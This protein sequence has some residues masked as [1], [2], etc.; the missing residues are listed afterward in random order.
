MKQ[1][2]IMQIRD[3]LSNNQSSAN[4][5]QICCYPIYLIF[6]N[7]IKILRKSLTNTFSE[8]QWQNIVEQ[9]YK[10]VIN[11]VL[12]KTLAYEYRLAKE[13]GLIAHSENAKTYIESDGMLSLTNDIDWWSYI[14][15]KYSALNFILFN[16]VNNVSSYIKHVSNI[17]AN[18][19]QYL[20]KHSDDFRAL[21]SI[22]LFI[23]DMHHDRSVTAFNFHN[24]TRWYLKDR[25]TSNECFLK[26]F[27]SI[28]NQ[29][30]ADIRL[31]IPYS[32]DMETH[33]W[34]KHINNVDV[35]VH[36]S[37]QDYYQNLGKL[38]CIFHIVHSQDII[39]DNI[40]SNE[41]VPC[42]VDYECVF[43]KY[44]DKSEGID[45][46]YVN[47]VICTGILPTW[48]LSGINDRNS[49]SSVL[50]PFWN[51]NNHIP[52]KEGSLMPI[53]RELTPH[54]I[55]GFKTTYN[56]IKNNSLKISEELEAYFK[57]DNTYVSR[58]II[59]PTS[60]YTLL[61]N[62]L[63]TPETL[64]DF[65]SFKDLVFKLNVD[66]LPSSMKDRV[67][68]SIIRSMECISVP[69]FYIKNDKRGLYDSFGS[70]V[71]ENY[72]FSIEQG[73]RNVINRI[74]NMSEQDLYFQTSIIE[75]SIKTFL[76]ASSPL[77]FKQFELQ[78]CVHDKSKLLMAAT[79]IASMIEN[80]IFFKDGC[81]NIV[82]KSRSQIDGHYQVLPLNSN[83]YD[84]YG[85][86][87]VFFE[88]LSKLT[89]TP[90]YAEL[91]SGLFDSLKKFTQEYIQDIHS[92]D[93]NLSAMTGIM[94]TLYI[95]ELFPD[96]FFDSKLYTSVVK[97]V[98][99][100]IPNIKS[101]DFLTGT[102]GVL[103]FILNA[104]K[105]NSAHKG[106]IISLCLDLLNKEKHQKADGCVY[107][108]YL[109]GYGDSRKEL[110]LG[111]FAHGSS[112]AAAILYEAYEFTRNSA[113]LSL[114]QKTLYHD[115]SFFSPEIKGWIDGR[116]TKQKLDG[117]SWCH[118]AAG[119]AVSRLLLYSHIANDKLI[120]NELEMSFNQMQKVMGGNICICHGMAGNL[121]V[122]YCISNI[123][124]NKSYITTVNNWLYTLADR[125]L[126]NEPLICGDDSDR[127]LYGLFMGLSGLGYQFLRFYDWKNIPSLL[128]LET[129]PKVATFHYIADAEKLIE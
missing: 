83:I 54:F 103:G 56:I 2:I 26:T 128:F 115:R 57:I 84:G 61:L 15:E 32:I 65:S 69:S 35:P 104:N 29:Y 45:K 77:Q 4:Q 51:N 124:N 109:D 116:N 46:A 50:F 101:C 89:H 66:N 123:I 12:D 49:I 70:Q 31:G 105:M 121:E 58:I 78:Q 52:I 87:I 126:H 24:G 28:L 13:H 19:I 36:V 47:S 95:M 23:G 48:M 10:Y 67:I 22:D 53:T 82:C 7:D 120:L 119:V 62:E 30:G 25:N 11:K 18:D 39:P 129:I 59:H 44:D 99:N 122:M 27:I 37:L 85:G 20:K 107:W 79:T 80:K 96:R 68:C 75:D 14:L 102:I 91:S 113:I 60:L 108:N 118:G 43:S 117:G 74:H 76:H 127:E 17:Y 8:P 42:I 100:N 6:D 86:I 112:S 93:I 73:Q 106:C 41:G 111:G 97:F 21:E 40:I 94:G 16:V 88:T 71:G 5:N 125:V 33:S 34:H 38:L 55:D 92:S 9:S 72:N 81:V 90:K 1:D 3:L 114:A 98:I 63:T 110:E 64:S